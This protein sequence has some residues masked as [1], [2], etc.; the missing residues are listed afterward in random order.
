MRQFFSGLISILKEEQRYNREAMNGY[1]ETS[2][3]I[4]EALSGQ[5]QAVVRFRNEVT[6]RLEAIERIIS[7]T[8]N[9][10]DES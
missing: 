1:L 8:Y 9:K 7:L 5:T 10:D 3:R 6:R 2:K 4:A